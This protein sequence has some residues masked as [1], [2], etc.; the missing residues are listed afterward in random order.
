MNAG[1]NETITCKSSG[2]IKWSFN[3]ASTL[4][5]NVEIVSNNTITIH[6][7]DRML[8]Q[9]LY[10]CSTMTDQLKPVSAECWLYVRGGYLYLFFL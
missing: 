1:D 4:P 5:D 3:G 6:G 7:A 2:N 9:G 10:E 8:N